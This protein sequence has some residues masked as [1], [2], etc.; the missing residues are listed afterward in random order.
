MREGA[1]A[2]FDF[3]S[4]PEGRFIELL[5]VRHAGGNP[6]DGGDLPQSSSF[7]IQGDGTVIWSHLAP[8]YRVRPT[9]EHILGIVDQLLGS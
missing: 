9:P 8:N 7:L 6:M 3:F 4:D 5:D 1:G 2:D